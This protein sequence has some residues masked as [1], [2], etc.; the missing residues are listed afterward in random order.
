MYRAG[1]TVGPYIL[2]RTLGRG[3]F[4]EVWLAERRTSLLAM[5]VALKLP[6]DE[7]ADP[8]V[9]VL[10][11]RIW[12]K[13]SGHTNIV[14]VLDAEVYGGQVAIASEFVAGGSL[15]DWLRQH[16]G[17]APSTEVA[18]GIIQGVLAGLTHLHLNRLIHRD[19]KP[20][21]VLLQGATPRLTDFGL[22]RVL[23]PSAHTTDLAGTPGY[24]APE[25]FKGQYSEASDIWSAGVV[26]HELLTG[27]LPYSQADFYSLLLAI[28]G[29]SPV[30]ISDQVPAFLK[31]ILSR[32]LT[33]AVTERIG[34]AEQLA[35]ELSAA[36]ATRSISASSLP[37]ARH[38]L[39]VQTTSFV[40]RRKEIAIVKTLLAKTRLLA[41]T[42]SGGCGKTRLGLQVAQEIRDDYEDG[43]WLAELAPLTDPALVPMA[44]AHAVGATEEP[45]KSL[46]W[47][48]IQSLK[49]KNLLLVIDNCEHLL[50]ACAQLVDAVIR[51]CPDVKVVA[52]SR[53]GLNI[54]GELTYR[55]PSLPFPEQ[56]GAATA[57]TIVEYESALLFIERAQ[58]HQPSFTLTDN[59]AA[60]LAQV[61]HR[62]DGIPLAIEQAAARVRSLAVEQI[63][64]RLSDRFRLLTGGSRAALPRPQ[65]LRALI[66]WSHDLLTASEKQLLC[67]LSVFMGGWTLEAAETVCVGDGVEEGAVLDLLTAMV[68]KSLVISDEKGDATRYRLLE[69]VRQYCREKLIE[70]GLGQTYR[71][72]HRD[73]FLS[74]AEEV[75]PRLQGRDQAHWLSVL[76]SEHENLRQALTVC[77][78]NADEANI[79]LRLG[80]ALWWFWY[81]RS[82]LSEGRAQLSVILSKPLA[83][84]RSISRANALNGAG[85]LAFQ[86]GDNASARS[87]FEESLQ[88]HRELDNKPGIAASLNQ[89]GSLAK[90]ECYYGLARAL[91]DEGLA[92]RQ[93]LGDKNGIATTLGNL[94]NLTAEQGDYQY[95]LS[96][97]EESLAL[98]RELGN[99][100]GIALALN[101][102]GF[103]AFKQGDY[104]A[105]RSFQEESLTIRRDLRNSQ[106]IGMCL[107]SLGEVAY[108]LGDYGSARTLLEESLTMRRDVGDNFGVALCL[109]NLGRIAQVQD[110]YV[111][112]R[113]FQKQS[114]A[115]RSGLG[116]KSAIA[117]SLEAVAYLIA[118]CDREEQSACLLGAAE[119]LR[120]EIGYP[121]PPSDRQEYDQ[122][123]A[124]TRQAFSE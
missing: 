63:A 124:D 14:P 77:M 56:G 68:D 53:E 118:H 80:A 104:I 121:L 69:T 6:L 114:L 16:G 116:D 36:L 71:M 108:K 51:G 4:G 13:A 31:P 30:V 75:N 2:L 72:Q 67:R 1:D 83:F 122:V 94:G 88:I 59:N 50:T 57:Q 49:S 61:C 99:K 113:S 8:N 70:S 89:L 78:D 76:E 33:K 52:S 48:L 95:A 45:G 105:A 24:M 26:L 60:S 27:S 40:G 66:D 97:Q 17:K 44:V 120:E 64:A 123:V 110:D 115:I 96:L 23:K 37:D 47:T 87:V 39:P 117:E 102:L 82:H 92:I 19:L 42:G 74:M 65:T 54:A 111:S 109:S 18:V 103:A 25:A 107:C 38:N 73:Y 86:Q 84:E 22:T 35:E 81:M 55:V 119:G 58:F 5:Q 93:E 20:D 34:S 112:A 101:N 11:A 7:T 10:E 29:E 85:V 91:F 28:T 46:T 100:R 106:G 3:A 98:H 62:L 9:I 21:N 32:A 90:E 79:G 43:V 41:L 12:L 15:S